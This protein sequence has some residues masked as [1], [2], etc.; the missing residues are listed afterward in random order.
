MM[1][2]LY[3]VNC[4][5]GLMVSSEDGS[6]CFWNIVY[7]LSFCNNGKSPCECCWYY[8]KATS[9]MKLPIVITTWSFHSDF[10][11]LPCAYFIF[12]LSVSFMTVSVWY[13][14]VT[15]QVTHSSHTGV[16]VCGKT[17]L[18]VRINGLPSCSAL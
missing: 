17:L 5:L 2:V 15:I 12:K 1:Y 9:F 14:G 8:S 10:Q 3:L 6:R 16:N 13:Y 4:F 7:I 18:C 11:R